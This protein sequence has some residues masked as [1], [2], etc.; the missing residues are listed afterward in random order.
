MDDPQSRT[1]V[2]AEDDAASR[3]LLRRQL[4]RA[5]YRVVDCGNGREA[6]DAICALGTGIVVADWLMPEMDGLELCSQV[7]QRAECQAVGMVYLII[8]T[9]Y[10][11]KDNVIQGLEAGAD[12]YL[13]KPYHHR[14][15]LARIHAGERILHLHH[16]ALRNQLELQKAN[17]QLTLLAEKLD[18]LAKTDALTELANRRR[19]FEMLA[20]AWALAERHGHP[21]SCIMFD[22]DHFKR[23]NDHY[24]HRVGDAVLKHIARTI[25]DTMRTSDLCARF[26]GEEFLAVCPETPVEGAVPLAER[27]HAAIAGEPIS[28]GGLQ[29]PVT[30]SAGVAGKRRVHGD[31]EALIAEADRMLYLA[32][33]N[34]RCQV[35]VADSDGRG[36]PTCGHVGSLNSII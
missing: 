26:G 10:A 31:P 29:V 24:G 18:R 1:I 25:H 5:G 15:L 27:I 6:L 30:V 4:E 34:G 22:V 23:V 19:L 20:Q 17:T 28:V 14:E 9:A 11:E 35:W 8:L 12:D 33:Q 3:V 32:K 7:R 2:L 16:V 13:A 21:L 36:H